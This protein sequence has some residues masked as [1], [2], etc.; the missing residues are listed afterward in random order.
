MQ[1]LIIVESPGKI[2]KIKKILGPNWIVKAS[3]GH[4]RTLAKDGEDNLGFDFVDGCIQMRF[5]SKDSKSKKVIRDL[6][7]AAKKAVRVYVATDPDREGEVIAWHIFEILKHKNIIRVSFSEITEKAV[8]QAIANSR[9]LDM[10]LVNSGLARSCLDKAVGFKCSPLVWNLNA[11]SVGRVQSAVLHLVCL[12]EREINN[13][14]SVKYFSI[15]TEYIE[16]FKAFFSH[17]GN[18]ISANSKNESN[19]ESERVYKEIEAKELVS[20]AESNI[21]RINIIERIQIDKKPP[22]PFTTSTLQQASGSKLG[23]SPER[24][25]KLAQS[26]YEKGFITYMRTDSVAL[27][28][29]FCQAAKTWLIEKDPQNIPQKTVKFKT[30]KNA[31]EAH[32]AIRP[33]NLSYSSAKLKQEISPEEFSLY[34]LI[35]KRAIAS[36]CAPAV[37]NKTIVFIQSGDIA[38]KAKGQTAQFLG[39]ARYWNDLSV[40]PQLPQLTEGQHL[41]LKEANFEKKHTSPPSRYGEPQLVGLMEKKGIGRPS[42]YSSSIKTIKVRGYVKIDNKKIVPTELGMKVDLFLDKFLNNLIDSKFTAKM[43]TEL[44]GIANGSKSWQSY[45][46][47]WIENYLAPAIAQ[48]KLTIPKSFTSKAKGIVTVTEY[49]CPVCNLALERYD[50]FNGKQAKSLLRCSDLQARTKPHHKNAVYFLTTSGSW[51]NK[52][53]GEPK[54]HRNIID[55]DRPKRKNAPIR[56][57]T[58]S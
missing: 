49:S 32:E 45:L 12:Q 37:I 55:C 3:M 22:P 51:W 28:E 25:M 6:K 41:Q 5:E 13:F 21:H 42:T 48:A 27:S 2:S 14:K 44:D 53:I 11:K 31:Q 43:E 24:T 18:Y 54:Q 47:N 15:F 7:E 46:Y 1:N 30:S 9:K 40:A 58:C 17:Q 4:F 33:S 34:L 10:N 52:E 36:Q 39:Y 26:I 20:L 50:Y 8:K 35:W 29:E 23:F 57:K 19:Q 16:G 56:P 38:W